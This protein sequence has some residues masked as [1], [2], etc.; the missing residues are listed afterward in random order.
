MFCVLGQCVA[1]ANFSTRRAS[2]E[3]TPEANFPGA[4]AGG[5]ENRDM[6]NRAASARLFF[7]GMTYI[8]PLLGNRNLHPSVN[9]L[10][11]DRPAK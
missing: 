10:A 7:F 3:A 9:I 11:P 1:R 8:P 5:T 4:K 2:I 6:V